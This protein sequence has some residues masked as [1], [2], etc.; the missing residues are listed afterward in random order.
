MIKLPIGLACPKVELPSWFFVGAGTH[1]NS[2]KIYGVMKTA[3]INSSGVMLWV[4]MRVQLGLSRH[5][6]RGRKILTW[7]G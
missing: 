5:F 7:S 4:T 6:L 1:E 3:V 2:E